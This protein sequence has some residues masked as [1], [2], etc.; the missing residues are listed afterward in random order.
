MPIDPLINE[1]L[2]ICLMLKVENHKNVTRQLKSVIKW[3]EEGF[4]STISS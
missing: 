1:A 2:S 4:R 3:K